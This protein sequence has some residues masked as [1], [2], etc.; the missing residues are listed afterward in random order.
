MRHFTGNEDYNKKYSQKKIYILLVLALGWAK[1]QYSEIAENLIREEGKPDT[2][3]FFYVSAKNY[4]CDG[5]LDPCAP[6]T[7]KSPTTCQH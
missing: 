5:F 1:Q 7:R 4:I 2:F 6:K 3:F